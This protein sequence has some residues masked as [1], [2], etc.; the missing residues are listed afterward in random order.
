MR[1]ITRGTKP[2]Y[3][4]GISRAV[5]AAAWT[6]TLVESGCDGVGPTRNEKVVGSIPTGGSTSPDCG[7][8]LNPRGE[9]AWGGAKRLPR[10]TLEG[11]KLAAD[12]LGPVGLELAWAVEQLPGQHTACPADPATN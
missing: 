3:L 6:K 9:T 4:W 1:G 5:G 8:G 10:A 12:L 2:G 7:P 11:G